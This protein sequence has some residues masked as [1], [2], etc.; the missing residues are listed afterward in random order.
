MNHRSVDGN[1]RVAFFATDV[2]LRINGH[3]LAVEDEA[4]YTFL[5][6]RFES[7]TCDFDHLRPWITESI[8]PAEAPETYR[9]KPKFMG[10]PKT[11]L[12][13]RDRLYTSMDEE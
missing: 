11:D 2:F 12:A 6:K 5:M 13:D 4:A 3:H 9:V 7:N 1:K 8:V 10:A